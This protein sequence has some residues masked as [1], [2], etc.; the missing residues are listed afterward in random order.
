[1]MRDLVH[2]METMEDCKKQYT[3]LDKNHGCHACLVAA[4]VRDAQGRNV[5]LLVN[6]MTLTLS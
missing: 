6:D 5:K 4:C 3:I 2:G 1:M